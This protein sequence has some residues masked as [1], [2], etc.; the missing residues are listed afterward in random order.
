MELSDNKQ[1]FNLWDTNGR[2]ADILNAIEIYLNILS[3]LKETTPYNQWAAYPTSLSQFIFYQKAIEASPEVFKS[4][5][6]YD[7]FVREVPFEYLESG[8]KLNAEQKRNLDINIESRARHYT[9][10]LVRLG[11]AGSDR[12]ITPAGYA[13]QNSNIVREEIENMLPIAT[14]N[15]LI[16]RQLLKFKTYTTPNECGNRVAYSPCYMALYLFISGERFDKD[17]F[18]T[19]IQSLTPYNP[20]DP[21]NIIEQCK[22]NDYSFAEREREI[23]NAFLSKGVVGQTDFEKHITNAKSRSVTAYYYEFYKRLYDYYHDRSDKNFV[24]L[25]ETCLEDVNKLKQAFGNGH[26]VFDFGRLSV[27]E[28]ED[29]KENNSNSPFLIAK[30]FNKAFY[31]EYVRSKI[32]DQ[33]RENAD[34]TSRLFTATGLISLGKALPELVDSDIYELVFDRQFLRDNIFTTVDPQ[35]YDLQMTLFE[36]NPSITKILSYTD[37]KIES[38]LESVASKLGKDQNA[39]KNALIDR[40]SRDFVEHVKQYYPKTRVSELLKGFAADDGGA[41]S[42]DSINPSCAI[43]TAFEYIVAIA[44]YYIS[45]KK[46]DLYAS[47]NLTMGADFEPERFAGGGAGD[48]IAEHDDIIV[49]LEATMMNSQAQKRGEWEPV[50]RHSV[51]LR[52]DSAPKDTVTFFVANEL[53]Y[54]TINIWR[55]VAMVPLKSSNSDDVVSGV[56]IMPLTSIEMSEMLDNDV[57]GSDL[58]SAVKSSYSGL[59]YTFDES[60]RETIISKVNQ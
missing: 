7:Q 37:S 45:D 8:N 40:T 29:F 35:E 13:Y 53:D 54:N 47:M 17:D 49:M 36:S 9:S 2:R 18:K 30:D 5:G 25:K 48:I 43:P 33:A 24:R 20:Q 42:R 56:A 23:P 10:N 3:E 50:L 19:I 52:V 12:E 59:H 27:Y 38:V 15:L 11:L 32:I 21:D 55:A 28:H 4:H 60:W 57:R 39:I 51:N 26:K 34:T 6:K 16:L 58:I 46:Y 1:V 41:H 14:T 31:S 44:W 22:K